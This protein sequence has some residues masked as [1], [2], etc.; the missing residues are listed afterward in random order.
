MSD[1]EF[2]KRALFLAEQRRGFC[3]PN[4]SV[5]AV[6]VK[7]G[8]IIAEGNHYQAGY[9]HAEP[10][11]LK[12]LSIAESKGATIYITLEPCC[13]YGRTPPCADLIIQYQLA[14]VVFAYLDPNPQVAGKGQ[15]KLIAAGIACEHVPLQE[16]NDFYT[17]YHFWWHHKKPFLTAKLA[18]SA[19]AKIAGIDKKPEKITHNLTNEFTHQQ[20]LRH[21][22][23]LTTVT[24][25][26]NDDP[27]L[28]VRLENEVIS[29]PIYILDRDLRFP[30]TAQ[31]TKTAKE[32]ILFHA[33][34][35][36]PVRIEKFKNE[37]IK[38]IS[39][40]LNSVGLLNLEHVLENINAHDVW[41]EA[42]ITAFNAFIEAN[43]VQK[44]Y[45]YHAS[46]SLGE[47][48]YSAKLTPA[49]QQNF[50]L[51]KTWNC[52]SDRID[53]FTFIEKPEAAQLAE[54]QRPFAQ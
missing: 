21:D 16:I 19:D 50:K 11:A 31:L 20:R 32:I 53:V 47:H 2:L 45:L 13:H 7:D 43:L 6:V 41:L 35:I 4:P 37:N 27:L 17:S 9:P 3:A 51:I 1:Y 15:E 49:L 52:A 28:N 29:K 5:G 23:I 12:K 10:S 39:I 24:T 25:V 48:A 36:N 30:L 26:L 38:C 33:E 34:N 46:K 44:I 8:K 14:R 22:A 40:P 42:G 54:E 18:L